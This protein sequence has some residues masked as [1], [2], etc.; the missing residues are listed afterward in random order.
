MIP[1]NNYTKA[2]RQ[3]LIDNGLEDSE[4]NILRLNEYYERC[5]AKS[6]AECFHDAFGF[7]PKRSWYKFKLI[8]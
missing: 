8:D 2:L 3:I 6:L 7:K 4:E 5:W 1:D